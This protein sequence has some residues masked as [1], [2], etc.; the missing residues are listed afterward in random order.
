MYLFSGKFTNYFSFTRSFLIPI[1]VRTNTGISSRAGPEGA[2]LKR[3]IWAY[4]RIK[5]IGIFA[6]TNGI[7]LACF[8]TTTY[9]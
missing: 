9:A 5:T 3:A 6:V 1:L 7:A 4:L 8:H 2:S